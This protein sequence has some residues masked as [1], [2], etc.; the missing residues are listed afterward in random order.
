A[1]FGLPTTCGMAVGVCLT[2]LVT[3]TIDWADRVPADPHGDAEFHQPLVVSNHWRIE[4]PRPDSRFRL[5]T[6]NVKQMKGWEGPIEPGDLGRAL[7]ATQ[8]DVAVLQEAVGRENW[9][10]PGLY[11]RK[12]I[13]PG[14]DIPLE[15]N[16]ASAFVGTERR[17][18][19][20]VAGNGLL[21]KFDYGEVHRIPLPDTR[22]KAFRTA[23]LTT[24]SLP[25]EQGE[26]GTA[27]RILNVHLT[28]DDLEPGQIERVVDLFLAL[29]A[30]CVLAGDF[31]A[32]E[33]HPELRR[34]LAEHDVT[35]ALAGLD[36]AV[37]LDALPIGKEKVDHIFV[38][39]L[40]VEDAAVVKTNASDHPLYWADLKLP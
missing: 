8:F 10:E 37:V 11:P 20:A 12:I 4:S 39:G 19:K 23:V 6:W 33:N 1:S 14:V 18:G 16:A 35:D 17:F 34:M 25:T 40:T 21:T 29:Q 32:E 15:R 22:G 3:W 13:A 27:V 28:R 7:S 5:A 26:A 24:V 38:R 36:P 30:P 9:P 2:C 31:N